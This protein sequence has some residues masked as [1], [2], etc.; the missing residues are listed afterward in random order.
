MN[1]AIRNAPMNE[2]N[3]YALVLRPSFEIK[4]ITSRASKVLSVMLADTLTLARKSAAELDT[5]VQEGKR[6][7]EDKG[8]K[9]SNENLQAFALFH[10]AATE[11]HSEGQFMLYGCYTAGRGVAQDHNHAAAWL[12]K[13]A[14]Q[15]HH[16]AAL[17]LGVQYFKGAIINRDL[18]QALAWLK[19]AVNL[20]S[21]KGN[22]IGVCHAISS[23]YKELSNQTEAFAWT[24]RAAE[25]GC[26]DGLYAVVDAFTRGEWTPQSDIDAYRFFRLAADHSVRPEIAER[27]TAALAA[28]MSP[29]EFASACA[30]YRELERK[31]PVAAH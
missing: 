21:K 18:E 2:E 30:L 1:T 31:F 8:E 11:G 7:Y 29:S 20:L 4:T 5:I 28:R 22:P 10:R 24:L 17:V 15:D 3:H 14:D 25:F 6:L 23:I 16:R 12:R 26:Y 19:K 13:S 9:M 27:E